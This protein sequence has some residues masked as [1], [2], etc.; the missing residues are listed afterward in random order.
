MSLYKK[1]SATSAES[2]EPTSLSV[3]DDPRW[4]RI[5]AR[6]KAAHGHLWYSV[7]STG[8][9]C[10]PSC[11]SRIANP[12]NVQLHDTL[13]SAKATGFRPCK[14]CNPD[15]LSVNAENAALVAKA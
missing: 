9:Y 8:V 13:Q 11:P 4:A 10:R 15:G 1:M 3:A 5:V 6:D 12:K 14:R 7:S 2:L